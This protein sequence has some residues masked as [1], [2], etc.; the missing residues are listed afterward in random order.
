[1]D[2]IAKTCTPRDKLAG[3]LMTYSQMKSAVVDF[4]HGKKEVE[5]MDDELP[6]TIFL[7][8][9]T[10]ADQL[11]SNI[12]FVEDF[13]QLDPSLE[14]EKRLMIN[15]KV[16]FRSTDL[17]YWLTRFQLS[18]SMTSGSLSRPLLSCLYHISQSENK[19]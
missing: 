15:F 3:F 10:D 8:T 17:V 18:T 2:K 6:L 19:L 5:S 4:H 1:M 14:S 11:V 7:L 13:V 12:A 16:T 9:Y